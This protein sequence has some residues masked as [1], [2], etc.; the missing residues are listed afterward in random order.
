MKFTKDHQKSST[1]TFWVHEIGWCKQIS[2]L[3]AT[4]QGVH[5]TPT[6]VVG[7][8]SKKGKFQ[9]SDNWSEEFDELEGHLSSSRF[10]WLGCLPGNLQAYNEIVDYLL[11]DKTLRSGL[12]CLEYSHWSQGVFFAQIISLSVTWQWQESSTYLRALTWTYLISV[13]RAFRTSS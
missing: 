9:F 10:Y 7:I 5:T 8:S 12:T 2:D 6:K 3:V 11:G 13:P 1:R 4:P